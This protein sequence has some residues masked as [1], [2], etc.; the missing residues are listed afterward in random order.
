MQND[1]MVLLVPGK[2]IL[3]VNMGGG[4]E[5]MREEGLTG[6]LT[7]GQMNTKDGNGDQIW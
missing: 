3:E 2:V 7:S 1:Q 5:R 6:D 4:G